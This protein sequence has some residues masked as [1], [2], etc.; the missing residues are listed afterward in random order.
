LPWWGGLLVCGAAATAARLGVDGDLGLGLAAQGLRGVALGALWSRDR[1]AWMPIAAS[2][3]W[4]WTLGS[5]TTGGL[6]DVR[7]AEG[8]ADVVGLLVAGA[9]A[10]GAVAWARRARAAR[11][12]P[13]A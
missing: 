6:L 13:R 2:A 9:A 11:G 4:T 10:A 3:A 12:E 8:R 1:G 7:F 5:W